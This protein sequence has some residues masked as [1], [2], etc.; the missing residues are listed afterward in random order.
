MSMSDAHMDELLGMLGEA[1]ALLM[2]LQALHNPGLIGSA[3]RGGGTADNGPL[4]M[5]RNFNKRQTTCCAP[6]TTSIVLTY[7]TA[8]ILRRL[9]TWTIKA[10][11]AA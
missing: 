3:E 2:D 5:A 11:C 8:S 10:N 4:N 6:M 1:E 7:S 9:N